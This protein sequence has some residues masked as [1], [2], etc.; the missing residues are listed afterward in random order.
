M[1]DVVRGLFLVAV[2][3]L[4]WDTFSVA[5]VLSGIAVVTVVLVMF[6][7]RRRGERTFALRPGPGL[8]LLWFLVREVVA[9]NM[10]IVR[11]ALRP[12]PHTNAGIVSVPL[13]CPSDGIITFVANVIALSPGTMTV[14]VV[15]M[16][17]TIVLHVLDVDGGVRHSVNELESLAVRTFGSK[18]L[19]TMLD[20]PTGPVRS[21]LDVPSESHEP[22]RRPETP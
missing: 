2:W 17:P 5:N 4:L 14:E 21:Q 9:S 18:R 1:R 20:D 22:A 15:V 6:P 7:T 10:F 11:E 19:I 8:K 16:P 13:H 12:R 3:V